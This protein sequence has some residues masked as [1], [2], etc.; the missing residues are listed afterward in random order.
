[1]A[2]YFLVRIAT[3]GVLDLRLSTQRAGRVGELA[4]D[5]LRLRS[6]SRPDVDG[7]VCER[8]VGNTVPRALTVAAETEDGVEDGAF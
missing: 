5:A 1:M 4:I 6:E 8:A 7:E 3:N 2:S